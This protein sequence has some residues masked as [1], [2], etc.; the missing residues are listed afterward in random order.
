MTTRAHVARGEL[1][2]LLQLAHAGEL[3]AAIAYRGHAASVRD[4]EEQAEIRAIMLEE[5]DHRARVRAMLDVLD[6]RPDER[7][8]RRMRRIGRLIAAFC[9]VG[10]WYAPMY[11]AGRFER[12]NVG[13]YERAARHAVDAGYPQF[14]ADLSTWPR[15]SGSTSATSAPRAPATGCGGSRRSGRR[16]RPRLAPRGHQG[17]ELVEQLVLVTA[18][19]RGRGRA[20]ASVSAPNMS[21]VSARDGGPGE[22]TVAVECG[23]TGVHAG[24]PDR[25]RRSRATRRRRAPPGR[26]RR[27]SAGSRAGQRSRATR[28]AAGDERARGCPSRRGRQPTTVSLSSCSISTNTARNN[29]V[30]SAKWW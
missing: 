22:E 24:E 4:P 16:R 19:R 11:G 10:G 18:R 27:R 3:A 14:V 15:S 17:D 5:L 23:E 12:N 25:R 7:R 2:A 20:S 30:L 1:V 6:V 29:S 26:R 21:T 28:A 8:E 13:E 9:H